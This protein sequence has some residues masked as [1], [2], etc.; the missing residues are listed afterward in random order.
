MG[1]GSGTVEA[2]MGWG[3]G[4]LGIGTSYCPCAALYFLQTA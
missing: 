4:Q 2:G 3:Y 1:T